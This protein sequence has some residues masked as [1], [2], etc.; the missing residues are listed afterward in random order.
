MGAVRN[1]LQSL[2][3]VEKDSVQV[4]KDKKEARFTPKKGAKCDVEEVKKAVSGA[5]NYTVT[6]VQAPTTK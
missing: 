1:A 5:G 4:D 2:P 3:C 6:A